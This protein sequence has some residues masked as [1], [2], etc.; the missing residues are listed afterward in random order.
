MNLFKNIF[1][2]SYFNARLL[3]A[4]GLQPLIFFWSTFTPQLDKD[5]IGCENLPGFYLATWLASIAVIIL[6]PVLARGSSKQ[7]A[8]AII[9]LF[10]PALLCLLGWASILEMQW[11]RLNH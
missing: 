1:N 3:L 6:L 9:L 10:F 4:L 8:G 2:T 5:Y 7:R 11:Q